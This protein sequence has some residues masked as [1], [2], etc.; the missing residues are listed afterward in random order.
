MFRTATVAMAFTNTVTSNGCS[1]VVEVEP[2]RL[3]EAGDNSNPLDANEDECPPEDVQHLDRDEQNPQRNREFNA[4]GEEA[5]AVVSDEHTQSGQQTDG[6]PPQL[7]DER[8]ETTELRLAYRA[9][10]IQN[11]E[12]REPARGV[13]R[14]RFRGCLVNSS[15]R[16]HVRLP[17]KLSP[18]ERRTS[19]HRILLRHHYGRVDEPP[20]MA[21][22]KPR[23]VGSW[24]IAASTSQ[25]NR[26]RA[27]RGARQYAAVTTSAGTNAR[28]LTGTNSP[29]GTPSRVT[30]KASPLSSDRMIRPLSLRSSR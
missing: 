19:S 5:R 17:L 7:R 21:V 9:A 25:R 8:Q 18:F 1:H 15:S 4:L 12:C 3:R 6:P 26:V 14:P 10:G 30:V 27:I 20:R 29:T 16:V 23:G 2:V 28:G 24:L 13:G 11:R 22:L